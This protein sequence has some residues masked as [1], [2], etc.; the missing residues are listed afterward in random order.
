MRWRK[1]KKKTGEGEADPDVG[2]LFTVLDKAVYIVF[3]VVEYPVRPHT[4]SLGFPQVKV[5]LS[6]MSGEIR[7]HQ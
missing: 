5:F 1:K 4:E 2:R 7:G 3:P 6:T